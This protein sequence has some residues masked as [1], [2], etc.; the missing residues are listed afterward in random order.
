[1][2]FTF[3]KQFD[4]YFLNGPHLCLGGRRQSQDGGLGHRQAALLVHTVGHDWPSQNDP[5]N[6]QTRIQEKATAEGVKVYE[7]K[8]INSMCKSCVCPV[9]L[10]RCV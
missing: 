1:M 7:K 6:T 8:N 2:T 9:A 4:V 3:V 5:Q 10:P